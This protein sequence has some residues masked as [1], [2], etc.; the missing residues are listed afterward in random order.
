MHANDWRHKHWS[1]ITSFLHHLSTQTD[2]FILKG[3]T[4][5]IY[6]Y[7]LERFS[8]DID[9]DAIN[10]D[11]ESIVKSFCISNKFHYTSKKHSNTTKRYMIHYDET[12]P[13]KIE[14]SYRNKFITDTCLVKDVLTYKINKLFAQK[15]HAF[16]G[17]NQLRD[18]YDIIFISLHYWDD[19]TEQSKASLTEALHYKELGYIQYMLNSQTYHFIDNDILLLNVLELFEML[20]IN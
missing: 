10:G 9:L 8:E 18:L 19:L 15:L 16:I 6:C 1:I 14:V 20:E 17:R 5:L 4:A 12:N 2:R 13:L 3:G 11:L 7:G